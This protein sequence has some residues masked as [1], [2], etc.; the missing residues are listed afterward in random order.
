ERLATRE[1]DYDSRVAARIKRGAAATAEDYLAL[2]AARRSAI[3]RFEMLARDC[4]ALAFPTVPIVP[5]LL[6]PLERDDD[7]YARTNLLLLRNTSLINFLDGCALSLPC[8]APGEAPASLM[9]CAPAMRD[10]RVL[11]VGHAVEVALGGITS[12]SSD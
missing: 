1:A 6:E 11:R 9:L 12:N 5:P 4:D 2:L 8:Q 10:G 3:A 7:A